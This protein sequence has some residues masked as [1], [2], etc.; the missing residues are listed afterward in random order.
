MRTIVLATTA[1]LVAAIA[2]AALWLSLA[3]RPAELSPAMVNI[4]GADIGGPFELTA[5]SGERISSE[6]LID[7]PT[8][9]YFGYTFCPDV[10]PVDTQIIAEAVDIL[11]GQG[12]EVTPV[13]ITVDPERDT[14]EA[15]AD[16]AEAVHPRMVALTGTPDEIRAAAD[17]YKVFYQK[18]EMEDSAAGYLMNHT[19]YFYLMTPEQG[20]T[21]LFRRDVTPESLASDIARVLAAA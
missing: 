7:G 12:I 8:L 15:L 11:A 17:A 3:P 4:E 10:C 20:L 16:Y 9:I 18:V 21:A 5:Q 19:S 13:F 2:A 1:A 6:Q 14:P